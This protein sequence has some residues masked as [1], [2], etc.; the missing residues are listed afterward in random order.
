MLPASHNEG[1]R[2]R[3]TEVVGQS[4]EQRA[5]ERRAPT[6]Y[7]IPVCPFSQRLEILL[8]L[9]GCRHLVDFHVVDITRPYPGWLLE[10]TRGRRPCRCSRAGWAGSSRRVW[11]SSATSRPLP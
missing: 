2:I 7:H 5:G 1:R 9:K 11:L 3:M 10:K 8:T 4:G 6:V